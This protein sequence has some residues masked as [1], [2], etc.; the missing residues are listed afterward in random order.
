MQIMVRVEPKILAIFKETSNIEKTIFIDKQK[1]VQL[2]N[3]IATTTNSLGVIEAQ[4]KE[5]E[6]QWI[7]LKRCHLC[8]RVG[9]DRDSR[10]RMHLKG[11][12]KHGLGFGGNFDVKDNGKSHQNDNGKVI[13][14]N[15]E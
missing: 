3:E 7:Q 10:E 14:I 11:S 8:A 15:N 12:S 5:K 6:F 13:T 9:Y 1:I 4:L 2:D